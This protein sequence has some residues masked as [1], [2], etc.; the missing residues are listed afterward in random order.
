MSKINFRTLEIMN[1]KLSVPTQILELADNSGQYHHELETMFNALWH[2]YLKNKSGI[3]LPYW[4]DRVGN[5]VVL[6]RFLKHLSKAGWITTDVEPKRNWGEA[7]FNEAKLYKWVNSE[8][9]VH[10]RRFNKFEMYRMDK[11]DKNS[12][13]NKTKTAS[14]KVTDTG[15]VRKGFAKM[16]TNKFTFDT[17]MLKKYKKAIILNVTKSMRMLELEYDAF[18]DN[19]DYQAVSEE[20]VEYYLINDGH[21][22]L[23]QVISDSRGRAIPEALK[24]V[25][26]PL[27]FKDA[28]ALLVPQGENWIISNH[29]AFL[30]L[31]KTNKDVFLF[32][33][34]LLGYKPKS[35]L[36]KATMGHKAYKERT[37]HELDLSTEEGRADLHE[38]IWLERLYDA[39]DRNALDVPIELDFTASMLQV[40]GLLLDHA[41]FLDRTNVIGEE[42]KDVW[43]IEGIPRNQFK[44]AMTPMLYGSS[45]SAKVLWKNAKLDYTPEQV[46]KFNKEISSGDFAVADKFKDFI[47]NNVQPQETMQVKVWNEE[48]TI[49]CNRF[50]QIG[51]YTQRYDLYCSK[52]DV[53]KSIYH[54]HTKSVAD[55]T[56]FKRYFVT[57]LVHNLDSQ[58][59]DYIVENYT[60]KTTVQYLAKEIYY[61]I[62]SNRKEIIR[63]YF[64]S[65][66]IDFKSSVEWTELTK[67][68]KPVGKLKLEDTLLK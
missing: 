61:R 43:T 35:H 45:Q 30:V 37:L 5:L 27:G 6:N 29:D 47:I 60:D 65:I 55:L 41:P 52:D 28:R 62:Y 24:K 66:G 57:L 15:L 40:E 56:Q 7:R 19:T 3:S 20:L 10:V 11:N 64:G 34:E 42:L 13:G 44:K 17:N 2:N 51:E 4:A 63:D 26:N 21:Y 39:L 49:Q 32:I 9:L 46:R 14:G 8:D 36:K 18:S 25:F 53:V 50:R 22:S 33:S 12:T 67:L 54:T 23:G 58:I 1:G 31:P 38:N 16:E 59:A 48:F 68:L